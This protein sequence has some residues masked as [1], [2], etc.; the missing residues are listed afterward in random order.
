MSTPVLPTP[1]PPH[2][3]EQPMTTPDPSSAASTAKPRAR[4]RVLVT[5]SWTWTDSDAIATVLDALHA[6]AGPALAL[7][8]GGAP[9]GV[10]AIASQWAAR[11]DVDVEVFLDWTAGRGVEPARIAAM[12]ASHP[13]LCVAFIAGASPGA[14]GCANLTD[15]A[16]IPTRRYWRGAVQVAADV[17]PPEPLP[18]GDPRMS[19]LAQV[20]LDCEVAD[21]GP[22]DLPCLACGSY[23]L[24]EDLDQR[25]HCPT[26]AVEFV[27]WAATGDDRSDR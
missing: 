17:R 10:D 11:R 3:Q 18:P 9:T 8:H 13:A 20:V 24:P 16:N 1:F 5:G 6:V 21:G 7:V 19:G 26:C 27:L 4:F 25:W 15:A 14:T 2:R 12:V 22:G 23:W